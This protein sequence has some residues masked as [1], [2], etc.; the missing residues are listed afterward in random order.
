MYIT[1][2]KYKFKLEVFLICITDYSDDLDWFIN[3]ELVRNCSDQG[4]QTPHLL[5]LHDNA[6]NSTQ[7]LFRIYS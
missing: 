7:C 5:H 2:T 4:R 1:Y 3:C 6:D